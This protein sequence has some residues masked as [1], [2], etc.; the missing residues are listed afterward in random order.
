MTEVNVCIATIL[1][2]LRLSVNNLEVSDVAAAAEILIALFN[3]CLCPL[4]PKNMPDV[5]PLGTLA[6]IVRN[7]IGRSSTKMT[8]QELL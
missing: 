3:A 2:R 7:V 6:K 4:S 1:G 5:V 8:A